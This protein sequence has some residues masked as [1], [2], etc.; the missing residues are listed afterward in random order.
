M[1]NVDALEQFLESLHLDAEAPDGLPF[2]VLA[3]TLAAK[4][5][6]GG[7]SNASLV[8]SYS[9]VLKHLRAMSVKA[10]AGGDIFE[11]I[12]GN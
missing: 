6:A 11:S 5:D 7:S 4:I 1:K 3:R 2:V 10:A 8:K 9:D 12:L